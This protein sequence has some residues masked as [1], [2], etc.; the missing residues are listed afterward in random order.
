MQCGLSQVT[1]VTEHHV[2][3]F[4]TLWRGPR[5]LSGK[6][7]KMKHSRVISI[8]AEKQFDKIK[9]LSLGQEDPLEK[10]IGYPFQYS[11]TY[12]VAQTIKESACNAEDLGLIPGLGRSP[13]GGHG[14]TLQYSCLENPH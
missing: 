7:L 9:H 12:L 3:S 1:S 5:W 8:D 14:N 10:G 6:E 11:W 4:S 13:E 2:F